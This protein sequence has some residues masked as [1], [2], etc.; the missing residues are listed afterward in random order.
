M[1]SSVT[2]LEKS[3]AVPRSDVE[4]PPFHSVMDRLALM[5]PWFYIVLGVILG[6]ALFYWIGELISPKTDVWQ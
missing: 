2:I 3:T 5:K 1:Q 6:S 4:K